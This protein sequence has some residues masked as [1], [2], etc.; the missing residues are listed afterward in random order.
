M[1]KS[2]L[3][4]GHAAPAVAGAQ[5]T[6][7]EL[8]RLQVTMQRLRED[9]LSG[10]LAPGERLPIHGLAETYEVSTGTLREVLSRLVAQTLIVSDAKRGF[11][12][13]PVSSEDIRDVMD[14]RMVLETHALSLAIRQGDLDWEAGIVAALHQIGRID[15]NSDDESFDWALRWHMANRV[16]H[17]A[18]I[19]ACNSP[20][21]LAFVDSLYDQSERYG[22]RLLVRG[23]Y[24][25][26]FAE[27]HQRLVDAT[28]A[29]DEEAAIE[30]LREHTETVKA[31]LIGVVEGYNES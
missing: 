24:T 17:R 13:A 22:N 14:T 5:D 1:N 29:R 23:K 8:G 10:R 28:L 7:T 6:E 25:Q 30:R 15:A 11:S 18:L 21:I 31:R 27:E 19:Q 20:R 2:N 4:Y 16:F 12:V 3:Q 26:T 9:I